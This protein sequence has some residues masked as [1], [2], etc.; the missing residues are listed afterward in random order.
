MKLTITGYSTAMFATWYFVEE[1]GLLFD[2]GDGLTASL[3]QKAR[4]VDNVFI[5]HA[6]RD[7]LTGLLQFNQLN[8]RPGFPKIYYPANCGSFPN[9]AE[10]SSRFDPHVA[11]TVWTPVAGNEHIKVR[12]GL[13]VQSIRNSHVQAEPHVFKSLGYQVYET[14]SKLKEE[15]L[16]I[17]KADLQQLIAQKGKEYVTTVVRNNLLTYSGDTP[18]LDFEKWNNTKILIH[19]AT[20]LNAA[21]QGPIQPRRNLHSNLEEVLSRVSDL[22]IETLIL[23][24]FSS[25]YSAEQ[26]DN[27]IKTLCSHY[28]I[29]IPVY[30][31]LPGQL[32]RNIL[33]EQPIN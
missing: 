28:Q 2:A 8:A 14:K 17:P 5:S 16:N 11:G 30:R 27:S 7:H 15:F 29:K 21:D 25:R 1:L 32:H 19:E 18:I 9:L 4:K 24:H 23:G 20:F 31:L 12:D 33:A 26:I 13:F 3:L 10:F 22:K 6:D